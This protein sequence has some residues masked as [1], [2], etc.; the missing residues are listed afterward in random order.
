MPLRLCSL[1]LMR[2]VYTWMTLAFGYYRVRIY[3]CSQIVYTFCL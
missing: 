3:V 1:L 2:S